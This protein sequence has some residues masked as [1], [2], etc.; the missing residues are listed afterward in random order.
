MVSPKPNTKVVK[1]RLEHV[2][3]NLMNCKY[4]VIKNVATDKAFGFGWK[5]ESQN[6]EEVVSTGK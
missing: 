2:K 5:P 1:R 6:Q 4:Q 3:I